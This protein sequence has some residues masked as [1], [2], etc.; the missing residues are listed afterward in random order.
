MIPGGSELGAFFVLNE[1]AKVAW[2]WDPTSNGTGAWVEWPTPSEAEEP[3]ESWK[4]A[5]RDVMSRMGRDAPADDE[6]GKKA[7]DKE[8]SPT[9]SASIGEMYGKSIEKYRDNVKWFVVAAGA[10]AVALIGTAPLGGAGAALSADHWTWAAT[11]LAV[12]LGAVA[13]MLVTVAWT[14]QPLEMSLPKVAKP[15]TRWPY[16][17]RWRKELQDDYEADWSNA[18]DGRAKS[19]ESYL[20]YRNAW[21]GT[22]ADIDSQLL[23]GGPAWRSKKLGEYKKLSQERI[24]TDTPN[25]SLVAYRGIAKRTRRRSQIA[26]AIVVALSLLAAWGYIGYLGAGSQPPTITSLE[27]SPEEP[28]EGLGV[29]LTVQATGSGFTYTWWHEPEP[30]PIEGADGPV[31]AIEA[32]DASA[33]GTYKVRVTSGDGTAADTETIDLAPPEPKAQETQSSSPPAT[34][35]S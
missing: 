32:F 31:L 8:L 12:A 5:V 24:E 17:P 9:A 33:A 7:D 15:T 4:E 23:V 29:T 18:L 27:P 30:E 6:D 2:R 13:M 22:L 21:L 1:G 35:G 26:M 20:S 14:L 11:R 28:K 16:F 34:G 10:V 19:L 3:E 25:V